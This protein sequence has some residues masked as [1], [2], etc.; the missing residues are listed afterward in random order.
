M[1]TLTFTFDAWQLVQVVVAVILPII[2]GLVTKLNA[3]AGLKA[4]LLAALSIATSIGTEA[5]AAHNAGKTY[6]IGQALVLA[7]GTFAIAVSTHYG[8]WKPTGV[9]RAA[10]AVLGGGVVE[11]TAVPVGDEPGDVVDLEDTDDDT[12]GDDGMEDDGLPV[13][14][15]T[16]ESTPSVQAQAELDAQIEAER[17]ATP[18]PDDYEARH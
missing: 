14:E 13:D 1:N 18:V 5:L 16:D 11:S 17:D 4:C 6:D 9:A 2:V 7:L 3:N 10:G 8:L 15:D 12:D